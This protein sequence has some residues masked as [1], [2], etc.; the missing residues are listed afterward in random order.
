MSAKGGRKWLKARD[1]GEIRR[2][3]GEGRKLLRVMRMEIWPDAG[4]N[5][6]KHLRVRIA[7]QDTGI[8]GSIH[9]F[10]RSRS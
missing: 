6:E 9:G 1:G 3:R 8:D 5:R 7:A 4:W 10:V 2:T